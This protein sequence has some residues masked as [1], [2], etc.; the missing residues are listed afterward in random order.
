MP[1]NSTTEKMVGAANINNDGDIQQA[2]GQTYHDVG[3]CIKFGCQEG[4]VNKFSLIKPIHYPGKFVLSLEDF[5]GTAN[6]ISNGIVYGLSVPA[7]YQMPVPSLIHATSWDYVGYPN[8]SGMEGTSPYRFFDFIHPNTTPSAQNLVGYSGK[9]VP[10]IHGEIFDTSMFY[11]GSTQAE[12]SGVSVV[13]ALYEHSNTEGVAIAEY[14]VSTN[15]GEAIPSEDFIDRMAGCY[16]CILIGNYITALSH[17]DTNAARP[18]R[19]NGA[20]TSDNWYV[21]MS[22]VLGKTTTPGGHQGSSPWS[23]TTNVTASLVLVYPVEGTTYLAPND[24]GTDIS[25]YWVYIPDNGPAAADAWNSKFFPIPGATGIPITVTKKVT[26]T[27][28]YIDSVSKNSS[29][30]ITVNYSFSSDYSGDLSVT[31]VASYPKS[32]SSGRW[33][34]TKVISLSSASISNPQSV[35]IGWSEFDDDAVHFPGEEITVTVTVSTTIAGVVTPG[36][37]V[38]ETIII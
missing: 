15:P 18:I 12:S 32:S 21:D 14:V 25:Q 9:A 22:K 29:T 13:S 16:P 28:A 5:R 30:G 8:A 2:T 36:N 23:S 26:S 24:S 11:I 33:S 37:S 3:N 1:W 17:G 38:T 35:N 19:Y 27:I 7:G 31:L 4:I 34:A 10:D 6:M 20:W